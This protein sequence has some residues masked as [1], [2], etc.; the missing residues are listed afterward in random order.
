MYRKI[1]VQRKY[2]ALIGFLPG[3]DPHLRHVTFGYMGFKKH[4]VSYCYSLA[5]GAKPRFYREALA[6]IELA[7]P[8]CNVQQ[9]R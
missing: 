2:E 8:P 3:K 9:Y 5:T 6:S 4:H 1:R 7:S